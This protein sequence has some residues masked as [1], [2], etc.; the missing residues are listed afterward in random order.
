MPAAFLCLLIKIPAS[1]PSIPAQTTAVKDILIC[2][3]KQVKKNSRLLS[4]CDFL[5]YPYDCSII[6]L[7]TFATI[8]HFF[9]SFNYAFILW[10]VDMGNEQL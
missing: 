1:I 5:L 7:F 8:S 3:N 6:T 9:C 2:S 4:A 10:F